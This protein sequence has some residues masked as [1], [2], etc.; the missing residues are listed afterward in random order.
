MIGFNT[1]HT[2]RLFMFLSF[3]ALLQRETIH[4]QWQ[5]VNGPSG[6][7]VRALAVS[8]ANLFAG[9]Q[10]SGIFI[11]TDNGTNWTW[12]NTGLPKYTYVFSF[13]VS[14][15][16]LFAGTSDGVYLSTNNGTS[17]TP[18]NSGL[19]N[20]N[21]NALAVSTLSDESGTNLIA[22]TYEGPIFLSTNNGASWS[23]TNIRYADVRCLTVD[24]NNLFAGAYNGGF[25]L[26]TDNGT[27][28]AGLNSE[29]YTRNMS[30]IAFLGSNIFAGTYDHG[31]FLST[32]NGTS[33]VEIDSGLTTSDVWTLY[34]SGTN[35]FAGTHN[36]GVFLSSNNGSTW[37]Q[38]NSGLPYN[39]VFSFAVLGTN[40]YAG[41]DG[42][43][44]WM[45][46]LDEII[47]SVRQV[48]N[49]APEQ[50]S[51][52]QNYPNPFNPSTTIQYSL[53]KTTHV[54]LKIYNTLGQEVAELV[55]K[56]MNAGTYTSE[57]N[58]S[59]FASGVYYYRIEASGFV[60]TKKL[61]LLK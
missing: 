19:T 46:P 17:W 16:Y 11:S 2:L 23:P 9:T 29:P 4:A 8:G 30:S 42:G 45:R 47:S 54:S 15:A 25:Y 34:I 6:V 60:E 44:I 57:W 33:W 50:F 20:T 24:G 61:L 10:D 59:G 14:G 12:I 51:F 55:S 26:S 28:W 22:G 13:A 32:N 58:A 37:R 35:I 5:Q 43:G 53:P 40:L 31:I 41:T 38:V 52:E 1:I 36:S 56:Q 39:W 21:V 7:S 49:N 27:S 3:L 18:V 48:A